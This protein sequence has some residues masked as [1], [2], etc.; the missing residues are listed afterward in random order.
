MW[1]EK[2]SAWSFG[3]ES[4]RESPDS[5]PGAVSGPYLALQI[6]ENGG[7]KEARA[8][9]WVAP[10]LHYKSAQMKVEERA[11]WPCG[12]GSGSGS[13]RSRF[14]SVCGHL[15]ALQIDRNGAK[16]RPAWSFGIES[17]RGPSGS[18]SGAVCGP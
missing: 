14:E 8:I 4:G 6:D 12:L 18:N 11:A 15:I 7:R 10:I 1:A 5:A 9:I 16:E 13:P 2:K 17:E 3:F